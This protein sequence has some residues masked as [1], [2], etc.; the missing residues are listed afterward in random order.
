[1]VVPVGATIVEGDDEHVLGRE[2]AQQLFALSDACDSAARTRVQ[3]LEHRRL[4]QKSSREFGLVV[5][6][7]VDEIFGNETIFAG[8]RVKELVGMVAPSKR[9]CRELQRRAPPFG[10]LLQD[11]RRRGIELEPEIAEQ[12]RRLVRQE[13]QVFSPDLQEL[14]AQPQSV[15]R[16]LRVGARSD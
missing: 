15:E 16:K 13:P 11:A 14:V 7:L 4:A 6:D 9:Q 8:E 2:L 1:M 5:E 10:A 12:L 3:F